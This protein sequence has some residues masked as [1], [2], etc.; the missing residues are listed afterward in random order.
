MSRRVTH[1]GEGMLRVQFPFNRSLV[2]RI[3][4]LPHRR[5]NAS[6]RFWAIPDAGVVALVELLQ[7]EGFRFDQATR[8]LYR[9]LG[10]KIALEGSP[11]E[12]PTL[13][14]LFDDPAAENPVASSGARLGG[15]TDDFTVSRLNERVRGIIASAFPAG[16]WLI[17][18]ISGFSKNAHRRHVSFE[19]A[20]RTETG[21]TVSRIPATLFE[22]TRRELERA[23]ALAGDP[24]RL[25]DEINVR[26][27]VRVELYVPWGQYRAVVEDLDV[28]YTLG[29]AARRREEIV[30][31]LI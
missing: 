12:G 14:G 15:A 16:V 18:E 10:G 22:S 20:E 17:G 26:L 30:R 11:M 28:N 25:E 31:R 19:L 21:E 27:R 23:L 8:R 24:Y 7:P 13:P 2:D 9:N 1:D 3:K 29:E 5:W 6:E 4:S